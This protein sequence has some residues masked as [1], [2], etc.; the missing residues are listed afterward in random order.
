MRRLFWTLAAALLF[1]ACAPSVAPPPTLTPAPAS[2]TQTLPPPST[3]TANPPAPAFTATPVPADA[4][5]FPNADDFQW[6]PVAAGFLR[7]VDIQNAGDGTGRL[8]V[9]EQAGRILLVKDGR[10]L[11]TPFLNIIDQVGSSGNEQGLLGLAF[12]PRYAENGLFFVNYTDRRGNTVIARFQVS[13]D[14]DLADPASETRLL[15]VEQ[16]YENHNGGVLA[17]GPDGYLYAGLG[18]G[19]AGGDP[20]GNGQRTDSL[21][22]KILR[23][24]VNSGDPYAIP[25]DNPFG[26]EVWAY[27]LRNPWRMSFD[28]STGDLWIGDVGQGDWEEIDI[29]P[30]GSPGGANFGWNLMEGNHPYEGE[31]QPG[32]LLP[33][34]EYSHADGYCSVTGG[35]VYRGA[36]LPEWRGIYLFGDYCTGT[37]W[38]LIRSADGWQAQVLFETGLRISS[39]G[40]DQ[41]GELYVAD[42]QGSILRLARK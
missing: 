4:T 1:S 11:P 30:A 12:H 20:L 7:P 33:V 29:L 26:S 24:D 9:V 41:A 27:G 36:D 15:Y 2:A 40:V 22:G 19:G 32:L 8:F 10:I 5:A 28:R 25:A 14:P 31:A 42:L 23:L 18:D 38:G 6:T 16:P 39:F 17:F 3:D 35:H 34:A 21:L 37:V 13:A